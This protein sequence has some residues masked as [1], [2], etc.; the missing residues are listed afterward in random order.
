MPYNQNIPQ[1][2]DFISNS[3]N[4]IL[5]NFQAIYTLVNVNIVPFDDP[6]GAQGTFKWALFTTGFGAGPVPTAAQIGIYPIISTLG[7]GG[8]ALTLVRNGIASYDFTSATVDLPGWVRLPSGLL[9]KWGQVDVDG[10][11]GPVVV[12]FPVAGDIP[13]FITWFTITTQVI[14]VGA[15]DPNIAISV[16]T[17]A[18]PAFFTCDVWERTSQG[19]RESGTIYYLAIGL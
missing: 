4:D 1:P 19:V 15:D 10:L 13:A 7:E 3:Q 6:S 14:Q 11:L 5:N 9:L 18:D 2:T 17:Y 12:D 8:P 16:L